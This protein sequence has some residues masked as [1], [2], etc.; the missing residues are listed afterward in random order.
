MKNLSLRLRLI[1]FFVGISCVIWLVAGF[2]SWKETREKIDEFF[3]TYQIV[4]ARQLATA[5]WG[6]ML[7]NSQKATNLAVENIHN[8][9]DEDEAIGFAVFDNNGKM[10]FHDNENGKNFQFVWGEGNFAEQVIDGDEKWRII[11]IKSADENY[12]VAVG[13]ELEYRSDIAWDMAEE[14]MMPWAIGLWVLLIVMVMIISIELHPLKKLAQNLRQRKSSDL[15]PLGMDEVPQEI[16]PLIS[17]MNQLLEQ[18]ESMI[19]R[20]RSFIADSAH[21]LRTP[22]TALKIQLEVAQLA[23]DDEKMR[24][25]AL[26][27]LQQGIERSARLVEQLLALS[28]VEA[29]MASQVMNNEIINWQQIVAGIVDEVKNEVEYKQIC[30]RY[31]VKGN[32][33]IDNGNPVLCSLLLRNLIDNAIKYCP[34]EAKIDINIFDGGLEVINSDTVVDE[35]NLQHLSERFFRPAGQRESGSGLGLSIVESIAAFYDGKLSFDNTAD[36]FRVRVI[37]RSC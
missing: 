7:P 13:Q 34:V 16:K 30:L 18:I 32:G 1:I 25:E 28:R 37:S 21:E 19:K 33:L 23:N 35:K 14:F 12:V 17:S 2:L 36:G 27:K 6:E 5:D 15:S 22:L 8:A 10:I 9:D 24:N 29:S 26:Q 20:E 31:E 4:L 3:D 11:Q